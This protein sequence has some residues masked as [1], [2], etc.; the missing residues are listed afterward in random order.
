MSPPVQVRSCGFSSFITWQSGSHDLFGGFLVQL[1][2]AEKKVLSTVIWNTGL[3]M[4][5]GG[6]AM[7][8]GEQFDKQKWWFNM[9]GP[10]LNWK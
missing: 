5:N 2:W 1:V 3:T 8:N 9:I 6:L 4:K 10:S 7:K